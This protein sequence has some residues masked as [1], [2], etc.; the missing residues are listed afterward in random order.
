MQRL[1]INWNLDPG[2]TRE[3]DHF[4]IR[5]GLHE[6][7]LWRAKLNETLIITALFNTPLLLNQENTNFILNKEELAN[8]MEN[9]VSNYE[10]SLFKI[11]P[12]IARFIYYLEHKRSHRPENEGI[13]DNQL[14]KYQGIAPLLDPESYM[15]YGLPRIQINNSDNS[16][17]EMRSPTPL[18]QNFN[19][20]NGIIKM[21]QLK[22]K[23]VNDNDTVLLNNIKK[24]ITKKKQDDSN[25]IKA[26]SIDH[27]KQNVNLPIITGINVKEKVKAFEYVNKQPKINQKSQFNNTE[28]NTACTINRQKNGPHSKITNNLNEPANNEEILKEDTVESLQASFFNSAVSF[29]LSI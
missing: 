4:E 22:L 28:N 5:S 12:K 9:S 1:Y 17:L 18:N 13:N 14:I 3:L 26:E 19:N 24:N 27:K 6:W 21:T 16:C 25:L 29:L 7:A 8:A 20:K 2:Y 10:N 23:N 15:F 11:D